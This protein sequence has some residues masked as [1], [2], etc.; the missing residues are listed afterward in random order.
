MFKELA[1][2]VLF[3]KRLVRR[4]RYRK[5][6]PLWKP[7]LAKDRKFWDTALKT[8]RD[9]EKILIATSVGSHLAGTTLESV[10]AVALTLRGTDVHVFLCDGAL[11][12]CLACW[13]DVYP[14]YEKF[15]TYGPAKDCRACFE[16]AYDMYRSLGLPVYRY[17]DFLTDDNRKTAEDISSSLPLS[18]IASFKMDEIVVGEHAMAGAL[19]FLTRGTLEGE[20]YGER[21][22]RRYFH[23]SL[24][25]TFATA[26]LL[27]KY[28]FLSAVFHHGIYVPQ[29]LIGEVCRKQQVHV[30]NWN[31]AY[32][33]NCFIFSHH[34]TY[35]HT[36]LAEPIEKW[37]DIPWNEQRETE[38]MDYLQSRWHGTQDWIWFHEKPEFELQKIADRLGID[39]SRTCV[40]LLTSVMW[41]AVLH[42]PSN[43]FPNMLEWIKTTIEYFI[44]RPELQLIIRIHPGEIRGTLPARQR[45][46]DEIAGA[47]PA[48][49]KNIT[50]IPPEADISTYA[51]M[52]Q[53]D[54]VIIYNTKTGIELAAM[55]IPVIV[56]G[57]AWIRNKG[58]A[59]DVGNREEYLQILKKLPLGKRM[60]KASHAKAQQYAYHFFFRRMIPLDF[61]KPTGNNPPYRIALQSIKELVAGQC[62]GLDVICNGILDGADFIHRPL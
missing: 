42:Y 4:Y 19:R 48:L 61:M 1:K 55:G 16:P 46:A 40:G 10:L 18:D 14:D 24:L 57:E 11:P 30:V 22:L 5:Y 12:A 59:L 15:V 43:A 20:P 28:H 25:A 60:D 38:L 36:L 54:A 52:M 35:H 13:Y 44:D 17:G 23:A 56:A 26:N 27:D 34:D 47:Y 53:C 33:K 9:G 6:Q 39:F 50:V 8:A 62:P 31:P 45:I 21:I 2:R 58:F 29:G 7:L 51:V 37:A 3:L 32:R 49:P 41:D